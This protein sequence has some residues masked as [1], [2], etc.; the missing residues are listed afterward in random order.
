MNRQDKK[1]RN[2]QNK[3]YDRICSKHFPYGKPLVSAPAPVLHMG[4]EVR[5]KE[6]SKTAPT[7]RERLPVKRFKP[8]PDLT[9]SVKD[10]HDRMYIYKCDCAL[11]CTREGCVTKQSEIKTLFDTQS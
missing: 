3:Q 7:S 8:E 4:Y 5:R 2:W 10:D 6:S 9:P 1:G 11:K